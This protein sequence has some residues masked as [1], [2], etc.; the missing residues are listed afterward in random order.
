MELLKSIQKYWQIL[1]LALAII[2]FWINTQNNLTGLDDRTAKV[3]AKVEL[4]SIAQND[5]KVQLSQIQTDILWIRKSIE[6]K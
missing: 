6:K 3:E 5:I 4:Q 1:V 2:S